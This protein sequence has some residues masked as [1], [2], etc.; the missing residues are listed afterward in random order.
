MPHIVGSTATVRVTCAGGASAGCAL[1]LTLSV[2]ETLRGRKLIAVAALAA[3]RH[4]NKTKTVMLGAATVRLTSGQSRTV[5]IS[6]NAR[7]KRLL[8]ARH[9]LRVRLAVLAN[10]RMMAHRTVIFRAR[11][12]K[13]RR[14]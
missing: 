13:K 14:A 11:S 10:D 4:K 1:D 9:T 7:G 8:G 3:N 5:R 12:H 2:T 6:L